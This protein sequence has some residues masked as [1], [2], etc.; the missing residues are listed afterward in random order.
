MLDV[1]VGLD[2]QVVLD[3]LG[4]APPAHRRDVL[5]GR[6]DD[7]DDGVDRRP[8]HELGERVSTP[9][10]SATKES[11]PRTTT[12]TAAPM[13]SSGMTSATLLNVVHTTAMTIRRR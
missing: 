2:P 12:S 10:T 1:V 3:A 5:R 13:S 4:E 8:G 9:S 6:L 7:P 11:S